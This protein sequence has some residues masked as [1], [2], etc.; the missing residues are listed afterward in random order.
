MKV[1]VAV[2]LQSRDGSVTKDARV[3]NGIIEQNGD[4][5]WLRKRP[6]NQDFGLVRTGTAQLLYPWFGIKSIIGDNY[7]SQ[8]TA[9]TTAITAATRNTTWNPADKTANLN[10]TGSNLI[11][12]ATAINQ[13][14]RSAAGVS[15]GQWYFEMTIT[16]IGLSV[17]LG[18]GNINKTL[19][20]LGGANSILWES[21][22]ALIY[23]QSGN[24]TAG[25]FTTGDI[26]GI[27]Y[28]SNIP[29][30]SFYK[31]GALIFTLSGIIYFPNGDMYALIYSNTGA[32]V[33]ANFAGPF[34]YAPTSASTALVLNS[35]NLPFSAA[36][37]INN[38][39]TPRIFF[40]NAEF[41]WTATIAGTVTKIASANYPGNFATP[42]YTVPGIVYLDGYFFVMGF[43]GV[44]Y[45]SSINDPTTWAATDTIV[46]QSVYGNG[47]ALFRSLNY[48]IAFKDYSTEFFYNAAISP[49]SPLARVD[50]GFTLI[51]CANG[52]TVVQVNGLL[53]WVSQTAE[54]GRAVHMMNGLDQKLISTPDVERIINADQLVNV[55]A[56]G[57]RLDGHNLYIL[58]LESSNITL[59]YDLNSNHV[60]LI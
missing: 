41:G 9:T 29:A 58:T 33:A 16:N 12:T 5:L 52:L 57:V 1:P 50:N 24:F 47:K 20:L 60:A 22:T 3:K 23:T 7:N 8:Y 27:F 26:I 19:G 46:A 32:I 31:N 13:G 30:I 43:N 37:T 2:S 21:S 4:E 36:N 6:G 56:I 38:I 42:V 55:E 51:G 53:I 14:A 18:I 45:N 10:L 17:G 34:T 28:D 59:V 11:A 25:T 40:K 15:S 49:G 48:V 44:I 39:A 35:P 54:R